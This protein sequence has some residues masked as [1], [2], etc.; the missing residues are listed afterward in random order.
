MRYR[1][2]RT[3]TSSAF[4]KLKKFIFFAPED[5]VQDPSAGQNGAMFLK[6]RGKRKI[7]GISPDVDDFCLFRKDQ[8]LKIDDVVGKFVKF[9]I[10]GNDSQIDIFYDFRHKNEVV[11]VCKRV[12]IFDDFL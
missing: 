12:E 11:V 1:D 7:K 2:I 5:F 8:F 10:A 4:Q 3:D 9:F 6:K